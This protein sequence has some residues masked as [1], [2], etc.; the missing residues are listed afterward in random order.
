MGV[1]IEENL[2]P[3]WRLDN[4]LWGQQDSLHDPEGLDQDFG[5]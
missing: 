4:L 1:V 5:G 3:I 2:P